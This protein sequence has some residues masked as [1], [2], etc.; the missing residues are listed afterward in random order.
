MGRLFELGN[1]IKA[2]DI[3]WCTSVREEPRSVEELVLVNGTAVVFPV[4]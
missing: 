2:G 3:T 1:L 4:V